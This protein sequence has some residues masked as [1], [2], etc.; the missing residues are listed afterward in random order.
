MPV[1]LA[2]LQVREQLAA[3][4]YEGVVALWDVT[5]HTELMQVCPVP[6]RP[7]L[8]RSRQTTSLR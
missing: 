1:A 7:A 2:V 6:M 8:L 3:A 4:D 5:T